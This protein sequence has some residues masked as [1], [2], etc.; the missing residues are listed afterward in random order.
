V[1]FDLDAFE[2]HPS[3]CLLADDHIDMRKHKV[4]DGLT[5]YRGQYAEVHEV[6]CGE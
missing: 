3:F 1:L 5:S 6:G 4:R 2:P